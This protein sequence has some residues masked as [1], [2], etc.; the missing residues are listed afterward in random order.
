[1][2]GQIGDD[3]I[4]EVRER[5]DI[6]ELVSSYVSLKRSG[7]NHMGLCPFH[8][9]KSPSFSVN[10]GR[11][12]FHCFGCGVGGDVFSFLMKM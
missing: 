9:E 5:M 10:A 7:A 1:M 3:K 6:V 8:S 2:T 12:F 11:Q 4:H